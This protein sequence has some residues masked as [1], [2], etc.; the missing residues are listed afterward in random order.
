MYGSSYNS[1]GVMGVSHIRGIGVY[2][3]SIIGGY[4]AYLD[5]NVRIAGNLQKG[6]GSFKIDH[7]LDRLTSTFNTPL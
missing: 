2:G 4:A 6:G 1:I 5:G 3:S 7:P